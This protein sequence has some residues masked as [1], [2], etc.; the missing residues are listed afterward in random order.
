PQ[1]VDA[2][3]QHA[4]VGHEA[5]IAGPVLEDLA[6]ADAEGASVRA[7]AFAGTGAGI[8][9]AAAASPA[10]ALSTARGAR[11]DE[12]AHGGGDLLIAV[13]VVARARRIAGGDGDRSRRH[14][15]SRAGDRRRGAM[16]ESW[17]AVHQ[18]CAWL[19]RK[20][21][22]LRTARRQRPLPVA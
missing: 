1:R 21:A 16:V 9:A 8:P 2:G 12:R 5:R 15:G 6:L 7:T 22:G 18:P 10:L 11:V 19:A 13:D 14:V 3:V 4:K 20:R 17:M